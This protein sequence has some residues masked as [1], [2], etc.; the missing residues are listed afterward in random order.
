MICQDDKKL[1]FTTLAR[2][3]FILH[4]ISERVMKLA[5]DFTEHGP[6]A[7]NIITYVK[8][9]KEIIELII[10]A[11]KKAGRK[12]FGY[13]RSPDLVR[14]GQLLML[15]KCLLSC[16]LRRQPLPESCIKS[17]IRL[18][19]DVSKYDTTTAKDF[20]KAVYKRRRELWTV[21]KECEDRR[22]AWLKELA[23]DR[24]RAAG[25]TDWE[26]K[27]NAMRRTVEERQINRKL[28][29]ITK[30]THSQLD[31]IQIPT[32]SWYYSKKE[33]EIYHYDKGVWEAYP[34]LSEES[35]TYF[36]HHTLKVVPP[37]AIPIEVQISDESIEII[38][39]L[40]EDNPMW[41]EITDSDEIKRLL[42]G[43]NKR[44][45][46]QA[47]IEGGTSSTPIMKQV[48]SQHGLSPLNDQILNGTVSTSLET[49]PEILDWFEA[50]RRPASPVLEPIVGIIDKESYQDMFK[51]ATEKTSSGGEVHYTLWKA[52]AEQ[53]DFAEFLCVMISLPFM[54]GFA[55]PRWSNEIDVM[56]E[57][58]PGV[59]KIHL[60]CIIGLLE[61]DFNT[62]LKYFFAKRMM[63]NAEQ[64]GLSDE[65]WGSRKNRSSIDAAMLKLLMFETARVKRATLAGTYY[66]LCANY[67]RIFPSI[68]NL[69]AQRSGMD[70]NILRARALVIERMRRRVKTAL[71]TSIESY[72]QE[73][74]EPEIGGEVQGKG[75]VPSL[76]CIQSDTLL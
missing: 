8:L 53:D 47:D 62:A 19:V 18:E 2:T 12:K 27:M 48:R 50:V 64:L 66:D 32:D 5:A 4:K 40:P 76:W 72:G 43:R 11:A 60:L 52:L 73:P 46:Q 63:A 20:R 25:D 58:K 41:T 23:V 31:C 36:T 21:Q 15:Y 26:K 6:T 3:Q 10:C 30:G 37:D 17:A 7:T 57:K 33:S 34:C 1:G 54:Y 44:H 65:Q 71:G 74:N 69:I 24:T 45:L 29:S 39:H 28:T 75:D 49:T 35:N 22:I 16:K 55:N 70:K 59:R 9:D 42:L 61:A 13:T 68:S 14:A 51:N 56:L 38:S 67:D